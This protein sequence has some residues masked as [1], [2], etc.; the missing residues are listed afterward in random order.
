[1][2]IINL[3]PKVR[4]EE[5]GYER[6]FGGLVLVLWMTVASFVL[7]LGAQLAVKIYLEER[8]TSIAAEIQNL[9]NQVSKGENEQVKK[10][11]SA[12]NNYISDYKNLSYVPKWSRA[13]ESFAKLPPPEVGI[14]SLNLDLKNKSV[15]I[16]GYAPRREDVIELYNNIKN[17]KDFKDIDYPLENVAKPIENDFHFNFLISDELVK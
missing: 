2:R 7:V 12:I 4:Q 13:L 9:K 5:L 14:S 8:A 11:I 6:M 17:S 15:R 10:K 1:M 16:Q 3:L